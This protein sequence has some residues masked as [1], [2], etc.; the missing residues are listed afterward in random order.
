MCVLA[1]V[2]CADKMAHCKHSGVI[3]KAKNVFI[4]IQLCTVHKRL[5]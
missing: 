5:D 4:S 2:M 1:H 3:S